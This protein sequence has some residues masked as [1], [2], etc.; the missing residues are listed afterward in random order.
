MDAAKQRPY[1]VAAPMNDQLQRKTAVSIRG[2]VK[3]YPDNT[4]AMTE[5]I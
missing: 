2:L 5:S 1:V 4:C 3:R